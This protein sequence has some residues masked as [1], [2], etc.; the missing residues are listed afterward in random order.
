MT[1]IKTIALVAAAAV[2]LLLLYAATRPD[3]FSVV[4]ST[5]V[6]APPAR[7]HAL[8]NDMHQFNSWNPFVKKD[9]QMRGSYRGAT[10]GPGAAYD[11]EGGK[12]G[13]GSISIVDSAPTK[14]GMELHMLKPMEARNQITFTLAPSGAATQVT[15]AMHCASP[16]VGKLL[17]VFIDMDRMIGRDFE[18]GLADL[19]LQA[20][21]G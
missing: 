11:F 19:K 4:R 21:R 17:G 9:P 12:S 20:E 15:W 1:M 14:V 7:L 5:I 8:I 18:A 16:F 10:A 3:S 13:S 6:Q 2:V